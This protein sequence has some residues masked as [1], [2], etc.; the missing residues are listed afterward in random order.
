MKALCCALL[1]AAG[2]CHGQALDAPHRFDAVRPAPVAALDAPEAPM[3][4]LP[5]TAGTFADWYEQQHRPALALYFDKQ[6][7]QLPPGWHGGTRL[8]IEQDGKIGQQTEHRRVTI[9]VQHNTETTSATR[10][11]FATL[12]EQSLQQEMQRH[13]LRLLDA[14][15]LQRKL[16]SAGRTEGADLEYTSLNKA[17]RLILE[18][19]VVCLAGGCEL[20]GTVKDI[21]SGAVTASARWPVDAALDSGA[22]IDRASRA[23]LQ[24]LMRQKVS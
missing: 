3:M 18:V 2:A 21:H 23:L 10:G 7:D 6:L 19:R 22:R 24:Q 16:A 20:L 5:S 4:A 1:M 12:F 11:D 17:V 13:R 8:L 14:V 15:V 9:G